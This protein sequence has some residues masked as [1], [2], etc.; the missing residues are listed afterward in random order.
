VEARFRGEFWRD[1]DIAIFTLLRRTVFNKPVVTLPGTPFAGA[2]GIEHAELHNLGVTAVVL[3]EI[4]ALIQVDAGLWAIEMTFLE[5]KPP[6]P[7][8]P[9]VTQAIPAGAPPQVPALSAKELE[10]QK[11]LATFQAVHGEFARR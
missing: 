7:S 2:L 4:G 8:P 6:Q 11:A 3:Q 9:A 10:A 5:Y 1:Q